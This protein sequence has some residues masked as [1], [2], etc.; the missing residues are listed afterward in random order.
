MTAMTHTDTSVEL[1]NLVDGR[2]QD[3]Q[4]AVFAST[5]PSRPSVAWALVL[6]VRSE[7]DASDPQVRFDAAKGSGYGPVQQGRVSRRTCMHTMTVD[8]RGYSA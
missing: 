1:T 4:G 5:N 7:T 2:W 6:H 3:G 8:V